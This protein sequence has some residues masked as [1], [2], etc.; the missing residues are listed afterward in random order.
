MAR[1]GSFGVNYKKAIPST[2]AI[3]EY[4]LGDLGSDP[5]GE[6]VYVQA[7]AAVAQYAFVAI[8]KDNTV[9]ELTTTTAGSNSLQVGVAQFAFASG[10]QGWVWIGGAMGG[11]VGKG[12]KGKI[13]A[14][15]VAEANL[16][17]TATAGVADDA[18]TTLIKNVVGLTATTGAAAVE[19]RSNGYLS[20]N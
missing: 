8:A 14:S 19:L 15:Y 1:S 16:N 3:Q 7:S 9:A 18:S 13:A 17:T 5:D 12:V 6:W 20:V 10:E 2:P 11:G 4:K